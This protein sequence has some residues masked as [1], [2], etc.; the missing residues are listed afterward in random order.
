MEERYKQMYAVPVRN[1]EDR[2]ST[3]YQRENRRRRTSI[4]P[5]KQFL[6]LELRMARLSL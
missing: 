6:A 2:G 1:A 4:Q 5:L 3:T